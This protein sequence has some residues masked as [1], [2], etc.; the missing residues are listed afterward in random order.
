MAEPIYSSQ[1]ERERA[2]SILR[3]QPK[4]ER[5]FVRS[6]Y[7]TFGGGPIS[8]QTAAEWPELKTAFDQLQATN[9]AIANKIG[10]V[11]PFSSINKAMNPTDTQGRTDALGRVILNREQIEKDNIPLIKMLAHEG[12]HAQQG[13]PGWITSKIGGISDLGAY[14]GRPQGFF[15]SW[16]AANKKLDDEA[17]AAEEQYNSPQPQISV[18]PS[19]IKNPNHPMFKGYK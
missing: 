16:S 10:A 5:G 6:M 2:Q 9:P 7:D 19:K 12:T 4:P 15:P 17:F 18:D 1:K 11:L 8:E 13:L 14:V 3:Q